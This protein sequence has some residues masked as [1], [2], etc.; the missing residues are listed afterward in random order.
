M[1][2]ALHRQSAAPRRQSA[3]PASANLPKIERACAHDIPRL[4]V[5]HRCVC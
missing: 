2:A 4:I 1:G 5:D 3:E